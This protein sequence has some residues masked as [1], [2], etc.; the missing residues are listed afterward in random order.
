MTTAA[1]TPRDGESRSKAHIAAQPTLKFKERI[2]APA[3]HKP[4]APEVPAV[5]T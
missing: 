1:A 4:A 2:P 5:A 3:G